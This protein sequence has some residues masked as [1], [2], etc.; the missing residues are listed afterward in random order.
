MSEALSCEFQGCTATSWRV[1][2][3]GPK[4]TPPCRAACW[5]HQGE[6]DLS[7]FR[8]EYPDLPATPKETR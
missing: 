5:K 4:K 2:F 3:W 7:K 1:L 8:D 6:T